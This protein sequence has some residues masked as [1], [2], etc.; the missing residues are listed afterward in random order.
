[1]L[2]YA[3]RVLLWQLAL[4]LLAGILLAWYGGVWQGL[5][6]LYGGL[7]SVVNGLMLAWRWKQ[8]SRSY[9]VDT[10]KHLRSFIRSSLERFFVVG[11]S[12]ALGFTWLRLGPVALLTG[13]VI[14]QLAMV[15]SSLTLR[16]R[17]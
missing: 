4:T 14:G 2:R 8:G 15:A 17:T 3:R 11:I 5:S 12:L 7:V 1:M 10:G 9:H 16:E 6:A 13:F